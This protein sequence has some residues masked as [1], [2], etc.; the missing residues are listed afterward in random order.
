M[1][2]FRYIPGVSTLKLD[3]EQC[4]GCGQCAEVCPHRI[5]EVRERK[6]AILDFDACIEC[7]ACALNCP[8]GALSVTPGTG[9]AAY[10]ISVWLSRLTGREISGG[11]C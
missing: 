3:E 2:N 7:G 11:C 8:T 6:A 4:V 10:I 5:L 9:C 1:R